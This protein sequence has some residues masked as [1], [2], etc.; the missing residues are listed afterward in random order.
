LY[1]KKDICGQDTDI[2]ICAHGIAG[3]NCE[4]LEYLYRGAASGVQNAWLSV[5]AELA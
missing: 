4:T 2:K 1:I 3:Q 5:T